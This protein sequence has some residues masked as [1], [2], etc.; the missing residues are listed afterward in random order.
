[1]SKH[2]VSSLGKD[3]FLDCYLAQNKPVIVREVLS[4][5][6][7]LRPPWDL[8]SLSARFFNCIV[9]LFDTLFDIQK[10]ARFGDYMSEIL[11]TSHP[12]GDVPYMRWFVRQTKDQFL[13]ADD[14]FAELAED[15]TVPSWIP[16]DGYVFPGKEDADPVRDNFPAKGFFICGAGGRT[17]LHID[18]WGTDACLCQVTGEKR[19]ILYPPNAEKFLTNAGAVVDLAHPDAGRFPNARM[20]TPSIDSIL[21]PGDAIFIPAGWFH[22]AIAQSNSVSITWNFSHEARVVAHARFLADL[23]SPEPVIEYF[24][25]KLDPKTRGWKAD[26][27]NAPR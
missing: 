19:F 5:E 3:E 13:Y 7:P 17:R 6:W 12:S 25:S 22:T 21:Y 10:T 2:E 15:W 11:R 20:A 8:A 9:P 1:V 26:D 27:M 18:P 24:G 16:S 4:R 14:A 23:V